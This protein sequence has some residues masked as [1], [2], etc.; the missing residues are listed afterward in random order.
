[1]ISH[2]S[3]KLW[4][5][6]L[7]DTCFSECR[8]RRETSKCFFFISSLFLSQKDNLWYFLRGDSE[9]RID[10]ICHTIVVELYCQQQHVSDLVSYCEVLPNVF[11]N[12]FWYWK[13]VLWLIEDQKSFLCFYS[14]KKNPNHLS[15]NKSCW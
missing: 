1:M 2:P 12:H 15:P 14:G 4:N 13:K 7:H 5:I 8:I 6:K 11:W 10:C 9:C 3:Q